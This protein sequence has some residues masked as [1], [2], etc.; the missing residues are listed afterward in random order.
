MIA[1]TGDR[2]AG[3][4]SRNSKRDAPQTEPKSSP[5]TAKVVEDGREETQSRQEEENYVFESFNDKGAV[6]ERK[7]GLSQA[8]SHRQRDPFSV[9]AIGIEEDKGEPIDPA[10]YIRTGSPSESVVGLTHNYL[11]NLFAKAAL[12]TTSHAVETQHQDESAAPCGTGG[13]GAGESEPLGTEEAKDEAKIEFPGQVKEDGAEEGE[14]G[15]A[16]YKSVLITEFSDP[17]AKELAVEYV[18]YLLKEK[19]RP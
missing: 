17:E 12:I 19:Q 7:G 5:K 14:G 11:D 13:T 15:A 1:D 6:E 9:P 16:L 10:G 4:E 18:E 3:Y 2:R 8:S